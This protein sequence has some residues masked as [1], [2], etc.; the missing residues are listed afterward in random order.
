MPT[1][2][3]FQWFQSLYKQDDPPFTTL[4]DLSQADKTYKNVSALSRINKATEV[5][6]RLFSSI[7]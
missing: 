2:Q 3:I 4:I 5:A 1:A 7:R 6:S